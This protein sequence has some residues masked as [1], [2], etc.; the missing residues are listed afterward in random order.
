MKLERTDRME[1]YGTPFKELSFKK[2]TQHI[3]EYYRWYIASVIIGIIILGSLVLT[4]FRPQKE[5]A[6]HVVIA[7]KVISDETQQQDIERFESEWDTN[8]SI[9]SVNFESV[10]QLEMVMMQ[11]IPLLVRTG[12]LD[13]LIVSKNTHMNYL[14][15][16]AVD[17]FLPLDTI[18]ELK[19][20]LEDKK[21]SLITSEHIEVSTTDDDYREKIEA[22]KNEGHIYGIEV[23]ALPGIPSLELT[24]ELVIGITGTV[25]DLSKTIEV[26]EYLLR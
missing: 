4:M 17:M 5:F 14:N 12:E 26:I 6:V 2:K 22:L 16:G 11:K 23:N 18:E 13:I 10:G 24:E 9:S 15:Q 7:G 20:L 19:P 25:K 8:L 21:D 1:K 3:W